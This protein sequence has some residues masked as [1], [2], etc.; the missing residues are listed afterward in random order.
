MS[1]FLKLALLLPL[2]L[3]SQGASAMTTLTYTWSN[4]ECGIV[5]ADGTRSSLPCTAGSSPSFA[6]LVQPGQSVFV[7]AT[8]NYIYSDDGL[9]L[10]RPGFFQLDPFGQRVLFVDFE[11]GGFSVLANGCFSRSCN[12]PPQ[13]TDTFSGPFSTVLGN[14]EVPD[15]LTGQI[16]FSSTAGIQPTGFGAQNRTA[17]LNVIDQRTFSGVAPVP[18]PATYLLLGAGL[19]LVGAMARRRPARH[20]VA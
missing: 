7:T 5:G 18:E 14:N 8:L 16:V 6:A 2:W 12:Q 20:A 17:F 10:E 19:L 13:L 15:D 3:A 4:A 9:A 1:P 11:A